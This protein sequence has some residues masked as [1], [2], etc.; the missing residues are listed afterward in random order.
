MFERLSLYSCANHK[1]LQGE[2]A[3]NF[4]GESV[5][6]QHYMDQDGNLISRKV[7]YNLISISIS[8]LKSHKRL[9]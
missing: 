1:H 9:A 8:A 2:Q 3:K 5:T 7:T 4:P 6:E